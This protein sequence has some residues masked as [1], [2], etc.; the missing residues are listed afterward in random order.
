MFNEVT[1]NVPEISIAKR[2]LYTR[3]YDIL[4]EFLASN[5]SNV[6]FDYGTTQRAVFARQAMKEY[7]KRNR[8]QIAF[9]QRGKY[10]F[11]F[12]EPKPKSDKE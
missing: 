3:E 8:M 9:S 12:K 4:H 1:F 10:V 6:R 7:A 11:A 2:T 5:N